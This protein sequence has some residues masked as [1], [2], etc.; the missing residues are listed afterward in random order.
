MRRAFAP[1]AVLVRFAA[2]FSSDH[3]VNQLEESVRSLP[4]EDDVAALRT[5]LRLI[6]QSLSATE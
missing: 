6:I 5:H 3:L 2:C 1:A 4:G